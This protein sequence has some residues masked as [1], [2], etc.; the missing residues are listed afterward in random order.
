MRASS[1]SLFLF[2]ALVACG[3]SSR[4][5]FDDSDGG[6]TSS[7]S[8]PTE[9][10]APVS[11]AG[12]VYGQSDDTLFRVDTDTHVVTKIGYF[13]GCTHVADIALDADSNLYA[14]TG[15]ALYYVETNTA[16]CTLIKTGPFPNSLSFVPAGTLDFG[17][18]T[19][20]GYQGGDYVKIDTKTGT[21][22]M[23]GSLGMGFDSSGDIVSTIG[24]KTF[25]SVKG[26][27]CADCLIEVD[28]KTGA[29]TKNWGAIGK[30]DVFGLAFWAGDVYAFTNAG[31]IVLVSFTDKLATAPIPVTNPP[32]GLAFR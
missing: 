22:T 18:E 4:D 13:Q 8:L 16:R 29:M 7:G 21:V 10:G 20:V 27:N 12:F 24:G 3:S 23:I 25:V 14:S 28:P 11:T 6:G 5:S 2:V 17:V 31:E 30:A 15:A 26:P 1:A 32:P 9:G 19:L